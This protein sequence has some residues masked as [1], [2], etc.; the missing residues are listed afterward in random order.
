MEDPRREASE[1]DKL[2]LR[3]SLYCVVYVSRRDGGGTEGKLFGNDSVCVCVRVCRRPM[4]ARPQAKRA[5]GRKRQRPTERMRGKKKKKRQREPH[6]RAWEDGC[7]SMFSFCFQQAAANDKRRPRHIRSFY[8]YPSL[9]VGQQRARPMRGT[10]CCV[11]SFALFSF[12]PSVCPAKDTRDRESERDSRHQGCITRQPN[13]APPTQTLLNPLPLQ[14]TIYLFVLGLN[15]A[16]SRPP[17]RRMSPSCVAIS[18]RSAF[19]FPSSS[20]PVRGGRGDMG[21]CC[22]HVCIRVCKHTKAMAATPPP[23]PCTQAHQP[24]NAMPSTTRCAHD[25][26]RQPSHARTEV[27]VLLL[28]PAELDHDLDPIPVL[29]EARHLHS[30]G[31]A[32]VVVIVVVVVVGGGGNGCMYVCKRQ[33]PP[34]RPGPPTG[35]E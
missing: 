35:H 19:T 23:S 5:K 8:I 11:K 15:M 32:A 12:K 25:K 18:F 16:K 30:G 20:C 1:G 21:V 17:S 31:G 10:H 2:T 6:R 27:D 14:L 28:P 33:P 9:S 34:A 7:H 22:V 29:Q 13:H 24:T 3:V 26:Q 4:R